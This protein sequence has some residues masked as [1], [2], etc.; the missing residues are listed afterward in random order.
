MPRNSGT[1][2]GSW[3]TVTKQDA[4]N[5]GGP[6]QCKRNTLLLNAV[7]KATWPTTRRQD[8]Y[9]RSNWKTIV[10]A[11]EGG[12]SQMTLSRKLKY[13]TATWPTPEQSADKHGGP[14]QRDSSGRLR[15]PSLAAT[16]ATASG[17]LARTGSF[18]ERLII[19]S[20]WLMGYSL[21]Y[22]SHWEKKPSGK[23]RKAKSQASE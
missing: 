20:A 10:D 8:E 4:A 19:L 14:N 11:N 6:S 21:E 15:L 13:E 1:D 9:E 5:K 7:V 17:S 12:K 2:I 3:P 22:L 18:V 23:P 16:G